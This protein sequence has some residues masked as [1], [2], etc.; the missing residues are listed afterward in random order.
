VWATTGS[1]VANN[2]AGGAGGGLHCD[3]CQSLHISGSALVQSN[4]ATTAGGGVD[5][6]DCIEILVDGAVLSGNIAMMGGGMNAESTAVLTLCVLAN[7]SVVG[8]NAVG[9]ELH[10]ADNSSMGYD[11]LWGT[12][13]GVR[14]LGGHAVLAGCSFR[15][16]AAGMFGSAVFASSRTVPLPSTVADRQTRRQAAQLTPTTA[17]FQRLF[18]TSSMPQYE[19]FGAFGVRGA[20]RNVGD[21]AAVVLKSNKML[22]R[23]MAPAGWEAASNLNSSLFVFTQSTLR[24]MLSDS[25]GIAATDTHTAPLFASNMSTV[26]AC[27]GD[28]VNVSSATVDAALGSIINAAFA[29]TGATSRT[30][31][32][33]GACNVLGTDWA[34][35]LGKQLGSAPP[36]TFLAA[37]PKVLLVNG[38]TDLTLD[39][40]SSN[41]IMPS[42]L[43][44]LLDDAAQ[45]ATRY[46][47][48]SLVQASA[49]PNSSSL[50][51]V[52][53]ITAYVT[54]G[55]ANFSDLRL[56]A[57]PGTSQE[58]LFRM[59]AYNQASPAK[60]PWQSYP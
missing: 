49:A 8:N 34:N 56:Q 21:V 4:T 24:S 12:G 3:G 29:G 43:L 14:L 25:V 22:V 35:V 37:S 58:V 54:D 36:G 39:S 26:S 52:G 55:V 53:S 1:V 5:C 11:T 17:A 20:A 44:T 32:S 28:L 41:N 50:L 6:K 57:Q 2:V 13:G 59:P 46:V 40:Y 15:G 18:R 7:T 60:R 9:S 42:L 19:E 45:P 16:N 31:N 38:R 51:L 10:S 48:N 27:T 23:G 30:S 33:G 47:P